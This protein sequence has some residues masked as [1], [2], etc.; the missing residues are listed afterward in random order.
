VSWLI[1]AALFWLA[2]LFVG[3]FMAIVADPWPPGQL[4]VW[5][6]AML[7]WVLMTG[8]KGQTVGKMAMGIMVVRANG[9]LPGIGYAALREM[10]GKFVSGTFLLV[11][12]IW[13]GFDPQKQ[14]WHDKI[15]STYV[16]RVTRPRL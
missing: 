14:G 6:A 9:N 13:T 10:V 3:L 5:A 8:L 11:G 4:V 7:Y 2:S 16:V 12:F 15:A 1:D